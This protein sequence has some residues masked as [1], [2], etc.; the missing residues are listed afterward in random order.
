MVFRSRPDVVASAGI[1]IFSNGLALD[2]ALGKSLA[3]VSDRTPIFGA[4]AGAAIYR[5][6]A[7]D[8]V[9]PFPEAFFMYLE[10]VDLAWRLRLRGWE[11]LLSSWRDRRAR[12]FRLVGG[13]ITFQAT[14]AGPQSHLVCL[15]VFPRVVLAPPRCSYR[16]VRPHGRSV[17][18]DSQGWSEFDREI[19]RSFWTEAA[20][21]GA[22]PNSATNHRKPIRDRAL[23]SE[24]P[25][26]GRARRVAASGG[27]AGRVQVLS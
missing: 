19:E 8:D 5:R 16:S 14:S 3:F 4:S 15:A 10:D 6:E 23:D 24:I 22:T 2:R 12:L 13:G 18:C 17:C 9:G 21:R 26:A 25:V 20:P 27:P 1:E 7:L 11:S